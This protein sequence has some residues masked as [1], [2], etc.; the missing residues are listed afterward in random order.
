MFT[1]TIITV[2]ISTIALG[3]SI[4][5]GRR[6]Q[7]LHNKNKTLESK[8]KTITKVRTIENAVDQINDDAELVKRLTK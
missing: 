5:F 6:N 2:I 1:S 3:V 4:F 7:I 8:L